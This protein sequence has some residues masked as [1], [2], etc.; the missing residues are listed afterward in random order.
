MKLVSVL[1]SVAK[2]Y[3]PPHTVR[4]T[5]EAIRAFGAECKNPQSQFNQH[6]ADFILFELGSWDQ[7]NGVI[8][9]YEKPLLISTA[10]QQLQ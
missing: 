9:V 8:T 2:A 6:P 3:L 5:E 7:L 10:S 4:T 1:D